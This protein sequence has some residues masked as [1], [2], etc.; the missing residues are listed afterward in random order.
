MCSVSVEPMPST[1]RMPVRSVQAS[2]TAAGS[3]SPAETHARNELSARGRRLAASSGTSSERSTSLVIA[4][5]SMSRRA[6]PARLPDR[7]R[8]RAHAH[9]E[10]HAHPEAEG[11]RERRCRGEHVVLARTRT[12][13][14][15]VSQMASRSRWRCTQP[16]GGPVVPEVKAMM[17]MSSA[18]SHRLEPPTSETPS[19][20]GPRS[21]RERRHLGRDPRVHESVRDLR[22]ADHL[23]QLA[24]P[25][26]RHR[27][28][29]HAAGEQDPE[30]ARD[31]LRGVRA[32]QQHAVAGNQTH[33]VHQRRGD[34]LGARAQ[35]A[36]RPRP[37]IPEDARRSANRGSPSST[38]AAFSCD[39]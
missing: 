25:Q 23:L 15:N 28:H 17:A 5:R 2:A 12:R 35:L 3:G 26:E 33:V 9:R 34:R 32:V 27:R 8:G 7:H 30:P 36:V 38:A 11:E 13:A 39:G 20:P 22:L 10:Q 24:R 21:D 14:P 29:H 31:Q 6:R 19:S 1:M 37:V 18:R 4:W 16:F